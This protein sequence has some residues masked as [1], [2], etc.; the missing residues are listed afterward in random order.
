MTTFLEWEGDGGARGCKDMGYINT[1]NN[2]LT[3]IDMTP[4]QV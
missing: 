2:S 3:N 4:S 1:I